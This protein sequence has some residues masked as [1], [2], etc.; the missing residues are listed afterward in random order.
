VHDGDLFRTRM[1][2]DTITAEIN[3]NDGNGYHLIAT[4]TDTSNAGHAA[5]ASGRPGVGAFISSGGGPMARYRF[6]DFSAR[7]L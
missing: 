6:N 1:I 4:W 3:Y 2:G 7:G 5:Y